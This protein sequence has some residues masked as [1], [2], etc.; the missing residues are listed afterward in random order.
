MP[1]LFV[2]SLTAFLG[3]ALCNL[4]WA[5][6]SRGLR[7]QLEVLHLELRGL[8]QEARDTPRLRAELSALSLRIQDLSRGLFPGQPMPE[9]LVACLDRVES[10]VQSQRKATRAV[11]RQLSRTVDRLRQSQKRVQ[12]LERQSGSPIDGGDVLARLER[13]TAERDALRDRIEALR[14]S[15]ERE[16]ADDRVRLIQTRREVDALRL[17][18]RGTYRSMAELETQLSTSAPANAQ[19]IESGEPTEM[20]I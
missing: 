14:A 8:R 13:V 6:Y 10:S 15:L 7:Q 20:M 2:V 17:Q 12:H 16:L 9:T 11:R 5:R 4:A 1:P 18:L 19:P 3:L